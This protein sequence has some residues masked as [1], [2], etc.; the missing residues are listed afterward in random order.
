MPK[1]EAL[2]YINPALLPFF[3]FDLNC[4]N[5]PVRSLTVNYIKPSFLLE[6]PAAYLILEK[7]NHTNYVEKKRCPYVLEYINLLHI[8]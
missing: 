5:L 3:T 2:F 6:L 8:Y 1:D 7:L 4:F